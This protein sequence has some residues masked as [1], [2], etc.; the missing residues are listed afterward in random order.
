MRWEQ[1]NSIEKEIGRKRN[2]AGGKIREE[3]VKREREG[4]G[5]QR[6]ESGEGDEERSR[7]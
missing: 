2:R 3:G 4:K 5:T 7:K 6:S 1:A